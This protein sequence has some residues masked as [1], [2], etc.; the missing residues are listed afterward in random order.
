[1]ES[2]IR[3]GV[4]YRQQMIM[5]CIWEADTSLTVAEIID[6]LEEKCGQRFATST[7]TTL[8]IGLQK[9]N[10]LQLGK[11]RGHA[12]T[13]E[14]LIGEEEFRQEEIQR[15]KKITFGGSMSDM[16]VSLLPTEKMEQE[17]IDYLHRILEKYEK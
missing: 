13:Y 11:K 15:M 4:G 3:D 6:M 16:V 8:C 2:S 14:A 9:K 17:E 5:Q 10:L 7:I 1:M 12:Y